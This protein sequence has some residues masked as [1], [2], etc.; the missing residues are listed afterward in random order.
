MP[1]GKKSTVVVMRCKTCNFAVK[2]DHI[3]KKKNPKPEF[4]KYCPTCRQTVELK[5][6]DEVK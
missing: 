5:I 6:K 1:R 2:T 3:N 4:K